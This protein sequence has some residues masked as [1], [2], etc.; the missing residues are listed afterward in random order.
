M[1]VLRLWRLLLSRPLNALAILGRFDH[2]LQS[3]LAPLL[4]FL[5][6]DK[7]KEAKDLLQE[8]AR[9]SSEVIDS[10]MDL[11]SIAFRQMAGAAVLRRQGL[12]KA[13]PFHPE[14]QSK[15]L[16]M[17]FDGENLFRKHVDELQ[18]IK[19]DTETAR[20]LGTLQQRRFQS[21]RRGRGQFQQRQSYQSYRYQPYGQQGYRS[22][23]GGQQQQQFC[24]SNVIQSAKC[25][26]AGRGKLLDSSRHQGRLSST[27]HLIS[28]STS[29]VL[30]PL[31]ISESMANHH[32]GQMGAGHH[33]TRPHLRV[34]PQTPTN[35]TS[36]KNTPS[37]LVL[38]KASD[39][40]S[41]KE[42]GDRK[43]AVRP[44]RERL[45]FQVLLDKEKTRERRQVMDLRQLNKYIKKH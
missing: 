41:T 39:F 8:G 23:Y 10:A 29:S 7:K 26:P 31:S 43:S 19:K 13:T 33:P 6:E 44:T 1:N 34:C 45:L 37:S 24:T 40:N 3:D 12:L 9:A 21:F 16:D 11:A 36:K 15:V 5:P 22:Q 32:E 20:S 42:R 17:P 38:V 35:S 27:S 25:K 4:E 28:L 14:V 30:S 2:Q 18:G